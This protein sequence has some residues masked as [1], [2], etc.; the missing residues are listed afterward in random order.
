MSLLTT[1]AVELAGLGPATEVAQLSVGGM[2]CTACTS[3]VEQAIG[4]LHGVT[5]VAV[6]LLQNMAKVQG[7]I[8]T[9]NVSFCGEKSTIAVKLL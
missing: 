6:S 1:P 3:S 9:G 7:S 4:S 2:T 5:S 8:V